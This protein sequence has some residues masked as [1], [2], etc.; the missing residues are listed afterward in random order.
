MIDQRTGKPVLSGSTLFFMSL[1][2]HDA[3][4][5][6]TPWQ[7]A[8]QLAKSNT[9]VFTDHPY[10]FLDLITKFK[11]PAIRKRLK[12]Y[13]NNS[14]FEKEG[15]HMVILPFVWPVNFLPKGKIY[16]FFSTLNQRII[17]KRI[18]AFLAK[19]SISSVIYVNSFNFYYPKLH[20]F[21]KA[22]KMLNVYHCIDPMVKPFTLKH[23]P[24]L[25]ERAVGDADLIISTA[26]A[27]QKNFLLQGFPKSYLVPNA[28]NY[29]LFSSATTVPLHPKVAPITGKVIGYFGNIERRINFKLLTAVLDALQD[30]QLV[31]AGPVE[32]QYVPEEF[33]NDRRVH[34]TGS[35]SHEEAP[36]VI[37]RFDVSIIPFQCDVAGRSIY[38]L[39][40]YEYLAAG[41]PVVS[42]N[43][44]PEVLSEIKH[45]IHVADTATDFANAVLLAYATDSEEKIKDRQSLASK[46][47]WENRANLFGEFINAALD[48]TQM[49]PQ[50][51]IKKT[52]GPSSLKDRIKSNPRLKKIVLSLIFRR[53]PNG[54][55][56]KWYVW[57]WLI[58][59]RYF[60]SGVNWGSRL[61][62][63][64][65][66]K[67]KLGKYSRV[68]QGV[69]INNGM[70]DVIIHDEVHTGIG[71][72]IIG[73]VTLHKHV[74]L[75]Q[76]VRILGMHHG[77]D[78]LS[79]H[80]H[81]PAW[82][83]PVILE[84]DAFIG[85]GTVIMGKKNGEPLVLGR[86]CRVGANSVVT[87]DIPPYSV[88]VG[89][90]AKVVRVWDFEKNC[91][92]K[93]GNAKSASQND[94][95]ENERVD[96]IDLSMLPEP[97][98]D[99]AV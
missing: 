27:L 72:I 46:H 5:T 67:F 12:A 96:A 53:K 13:V 9:V 42:T 38:P 4:Y 1:P 22:K 20:A 94:R 28:A 54:S 57:L 19:H 88:A 15:V 44:N 70:G 65:F 80:H 92:A 51:V 52:L 37:K 39:K 16:N 73:P 34:F 74:G 40:L 95:E 35:F 79:P 8:V 47:T 78:V 58:F 31:M 91:W 97:K 66:N 81:Q 11:D 61:D 84:E 64:P 60:R 86:Y 14:A 59:P 63:T 68:E 41:K 69:V 43:F 93:P 32:R 49:E 2:R 7:I 33:L 87:T 10:T 24:Y 82:R 50:P 29:K 30:W 3:K 71:C 36:A 17:A 26:P 6:S 18:N 23:G 76:Y 56:V 75:S 90:P 77:S 83:A 55:R 48:H 89:N 98:P 21:L 45:F 99:Q 85:T 25:Q 62:L